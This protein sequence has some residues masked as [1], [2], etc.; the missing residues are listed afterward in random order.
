MHPVIAQSEHSIISPL[1]ARLWESA[2]VRPERLNG[3]NNIVALAG[4]VSAGVGISCLPVPLFEASLARGDL[5]LLKTQPEAPTVDY[6]CYFLK[7]PHSALGYNVAEIAKRTCTFQ[8]VSD[9][10]RDLGKAHRKTS[11]RADAPLNPL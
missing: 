7:Y 1:C 2:G 10:S 8:L 3:G 5:E 4:L 11:P 9:A 6:A